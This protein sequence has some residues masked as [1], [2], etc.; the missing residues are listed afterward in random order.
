MIYNKLKKINLIFLEIIIDNLFTC[1][2]EVY[3]IILL[4]TIQFNCLFFI[5]K[6]KKRN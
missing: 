4:V 1:S 2:V 3:N 6:N 5:F